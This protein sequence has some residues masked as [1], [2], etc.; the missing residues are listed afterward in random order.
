[1]KRR[2]LGPKP[3][4]S[5]MAFSQTLLS[6]NAAAA[7]LSCYR[8]YAVFLPKLA[9]GAGKIGLKDVNDLFTLRLIL[10]A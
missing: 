3:F 7:L 8:C 5:S 6:S 1:M 2:G 10:F 4:P 9:E